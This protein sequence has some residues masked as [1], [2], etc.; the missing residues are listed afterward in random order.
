LDHL[1]K[2]EG[3]YLIAFKLTATNKEIIHNSSIHHGYTQ[4]SEKC[5]NALVAFL[6]KM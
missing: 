6:I 4:K 3:H 1:L 5:G 2:I